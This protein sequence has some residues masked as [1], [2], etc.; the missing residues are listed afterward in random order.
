MRRLICI[1]A[2]AALALGAAQV[3]AQV[4]ATPEQANG[5]QGKTKANN[6]IYI[7]Q[8]F[9]APVVAYDGGISGLKATRPR[10]GQKIDP[11]SPQVLAY[12]SYLDNKHNGALAAVG[13]AAC[14][15]DGRYLLVGTIRALEGLQPVETLLSAGVAAVKTMDGQPVQHGLVLADKLRPAR[16]SGVPVQYVDW[17]DD[18]WQP[19]KL[20]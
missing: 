17:Q 8:M 19:V 7:V 11:T 20:N 14:G 12:N 15:E 3:C 18:H 13:L 4:L 16:R 5:N 6:N 10:K 9:D 2:V 1:I